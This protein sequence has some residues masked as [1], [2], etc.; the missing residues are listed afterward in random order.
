MK[1]NEEE[2]KEL[3]TDLDKEFVYKGDRNC[4]I[5][6]GNSHCAPCL[7]MESIFNKIE[8]EHEEEFIVFSVDTDESPATCNAVGIMSTP[9]T[10]F[11]SAAGE[12]DMMIGVMTEQQILD[13]AEDFFK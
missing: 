8:V 13:K 6:F 4:I 1:I 3:I 12:V 2:F 9:T 11:I 5:K 10:L 7:K